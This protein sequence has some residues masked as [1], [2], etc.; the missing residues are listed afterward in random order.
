MDCDLRS[1]G[2]QLFDRPE[3]VTERYARE[4]SAGLG[5]SPEHERYSA[6]S[7]QVLMLQAQLRSHRTVPSRRMVSAAGSA[8]IVPQEKVPVRSMQVT[9]ILLH[10]EPSMVLSLSPVLPKS[11]V[12]SAPEAPG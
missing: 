4:C 2:F 8:E 12:G 5:Q 6:A 10:A 7:R 1:A 3:A 9:R 11:M